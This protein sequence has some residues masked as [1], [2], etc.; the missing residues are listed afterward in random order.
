MT[1]STLRRFVSSSSVSSACVVSRGSDSHDAHP[2]EHLRTPQHLQH[3]D[4]GFCHH[5]HHV[6]PDQTSRMNAMLVK[7]SHEHATDLLHFEQA[8]LVPTADR[9]LLRSALGKRMVDKVL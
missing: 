1:A 6:Y 7:P 8:R 4:S 9:Q 3:P 2:N 5:K